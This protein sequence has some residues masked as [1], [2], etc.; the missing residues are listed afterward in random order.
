MR[1]ADLGL[2]PRQSAIRNQKAARTQ[3]AQGNEAREQ[4]FRTSWER[5]VY[6]LN[7]GTNDPMSF[8]SC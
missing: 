8:R 4:F 7:A 2:A 5:N 1:V 6:E 3:D